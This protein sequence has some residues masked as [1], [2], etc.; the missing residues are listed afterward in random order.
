[1]SLSPLFAY[2]LYPYLSADLQQT[3]PIRYVTIRRTGRGGICE[4]RSVSKPRLPAEAPCTMQTH[5]AQKPG[6]DGS[7]GSET[8]G[9]SGIETEGIDTEGIDTD[10][11]ETDGIETEGIEG[12]EGSSWPVILAN[13][14]A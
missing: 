13:E 6:S 7:D 3:R 2:Q 14:S 11:I 8:E 10:G 9:R 4:T 1:M 5:T 12:S